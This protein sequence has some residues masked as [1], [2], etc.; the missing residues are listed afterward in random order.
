MRFLF[1]VVVLFCM[2]LVSAVKADQPSESGL[3]VSER[4]VIS[5]PSAEA[6][7]KMSDIEMVAHEADVIWVRQYIEAFTDL[8]PHWPPNV[9]VK[10]RAGD[11]ARVIVDVSKEMGV[12][13]RITTVLIRCESGFREGMLSGE[14]DKKDFGLMQVHGSKSVTSEDQIRDGLTEWN[15]CVDQCGSTGRSLVCYQTGRCDVKDT[16]EERLLQKKRGAVYR[17]KL[18]SRVG[19]KAKLEG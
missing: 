16:S 1:C 15:K 2:A 6:Y 4:G 7:K 9:E 3:Y 12:D 11:L 13:P 10:K 8:N 17:T 19:V 14:K 18:L 5:T